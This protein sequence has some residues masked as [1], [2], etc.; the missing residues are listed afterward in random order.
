MSHRLFASIFSR[1]NSAFC[2]G[3]ICVV[4]LADVQVGFHNHGFEA[5]LLFAAAGVTR[6]SHQK[7]Q[8]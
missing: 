6:P 8:A 4:D 1:Q 3:A 7:N 2:F 5:V